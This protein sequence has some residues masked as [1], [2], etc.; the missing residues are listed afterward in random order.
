MKRSF[1]FLLE[2]TLACCIATGDARAHGG[3]GHGGGGHGGGH[4]GYHGYGHYGFGY[5]GFGYGYGLGIGLGLGYGYGPY[6]PGLYGGYGGYP[7]AY[8]GP[9]VLQ[10]PPMVMQQPVMVGSAP[11][12]VLPP[13]IP[14]MPPPSG[15]MPPYAPA[16]NSY[17]TTT[18]TVIGSAPASPGVTIHGPQL[19]T[20][21]QTGVDSLLQLLHQSDANVRRDAIMDLGRMKAERAIDPVTAAMNTDANPVVR[22]AAARAL[23]LIGNSRSLPALI[24][25]AQSDNDRDVRHSAQFA[26]EVIRSQI[27]R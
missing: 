10:Q 7:Y 1:F 23:G 19:S 15:Q 4:Y 16:P 9:I 20:F 13:V 18:P 5:G 22:D 24:R 8:P 25:A 17:N 11:A 6:Y 12:P 27:Q 14:Q 26:I 21:S 3:G 2:V